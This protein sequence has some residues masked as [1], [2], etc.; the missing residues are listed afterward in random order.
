MNTK[1]FIHQYH[2]QWT[3]LNI[4]NNFRCIKA[5][6]HYTVIER[7]SSKIDRYKRFGNR[8]RYITVILL[9]DDFLC[10]NFDVE[11][12]EVVDNLENT[13]NAMETL[14]KA[15]TSQDS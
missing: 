4:A 12:L 15:M 8:F 7:F 5:F 2:R 11:G 3:K 6:G 13:W 14:K 10:H 1:N 9:H